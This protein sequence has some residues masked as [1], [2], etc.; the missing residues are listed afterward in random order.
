M[1]QYLFV[2]YPP[3]LLKNFIHYLGSGE[4][5]IDDEGGIVSWIYIAALY[6]FQQLDNLQLDNK[7]SASHINWQDNKM[8]VNLAAQINSV[9]TAIDFLRDKKIS[10]HLSKIAKQQS[11]L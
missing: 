4:T 5:V 3:H 8:K 7:M 1:S 6:D 11:N 10:F 2:L 9:A